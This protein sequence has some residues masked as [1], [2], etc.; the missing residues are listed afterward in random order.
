MRHKRFVK[1]GELSGCE[2]SVDFFSQKGARNFRNFFARSSPFLGSLGGIFPFKHCFEVFRARTAFLAVWRPF[3][4][5][6]SGLAVLNVQTR[7][8]IC[9]LMVPSRMVPH[10]LWEAAI[11]RNGWFPSYLKVVTERTRRNLSKDLGTGRN[12]VKLRC[13]F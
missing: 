7:I 11:P 2:T 8:V 6:W 10:G 3:Y 1:I 4:V 9:Y 13:V 12:K 5:K